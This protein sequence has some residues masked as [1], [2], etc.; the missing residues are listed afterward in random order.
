MLEHESV[1]MAGV[2][3]GELSLLFRR[4]HTML[5][6]GISLPDSLVYLEKGETDPELHEVIQG[7]LSGIL[8]GQPL[9]AGMRKFPKTFS[10]LMIEMVASGENTGSLASTLGHL[11]SLTE[12]QQDRRQKVLSALAYPCCLFFVMTI[13]V[14]IFVVFVAPG[15]DGL[16]RSLGDEIPWPSQVLIGVSKFVTNPLLLGGAVGILALLVFALRKSYRENSS[17]RYRVDELCLGLPVVG[18]LVV[19]LEAARVLDVLGSSIRIGLSVVTA[20][21][22]GIRVCANARFRD[23]L[24]RALEAIS[25]GSGIGS[26]LSEYTQVPRYATSLIEVAEESGQL[27]HVMARAAATLDEE[28]NSALAQLVS[29]AEPLLLCL[30]GLAAGFVAVATFLPII[31]LISNL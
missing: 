6:A 18:R 16:F 19:R 2:G 11:A 3:A 27:D 31:R 10:P 25:V 29:L 17:F 9:S 4:L 15:D 30:G 12:R 20:L 26:A 1:V 21:N 23:D 8:R 5:E 7:C 14:L 24:G 28:A 22:N 13:V